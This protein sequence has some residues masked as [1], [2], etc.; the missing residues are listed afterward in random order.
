M[1]L[2]VHKATS[3]DEGNQ[4]AV[5][6]SPL[7]SEID[8]GCWTQVRACSHKKLWAMPAHARRR[9]TMGMAGKAHWDQM[10]DAGMRTCMSQK[11]GV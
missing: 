9:F 5:T 10:I 7:L 3:G 6:I 11:H 2:H 8:Q 4:Q 1:H